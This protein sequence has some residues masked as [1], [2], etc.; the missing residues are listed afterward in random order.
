VSVPGICY[1]HGGI[2]ANLFSQHCAINV[3]IQTLGAL[4]SQVEDQKRW[5]VVATTMLFDKSHRY[6]LG[7]PLI[8]QMAA[9]YTA[10]SRFLSRRVV[11]MEQKGRSQVRTIATV[12]FRRD[13]GRFPS[14]WLF[15]QSQTFRSATLA[16]Q[17][18][19]GSDRC[20]RV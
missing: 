17:T 18:F 4:C 5:R 12:W 15:R 11:I 16:Q 3:Q 2:A 7:C 1:L 19:V 6:A 10:F 14:L 9:R 8:L 20:G 13:L